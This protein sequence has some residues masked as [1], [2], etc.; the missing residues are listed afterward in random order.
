MNSY[1]AIVLTR[2]RDDPDVATWSPLIR[3]RI[4]QIPS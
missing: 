2:S 1:G 3:A 4:K